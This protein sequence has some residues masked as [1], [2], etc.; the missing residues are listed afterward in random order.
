MRSADLSR[1][2][3]DIV[4]AFDEGVDEASPNTLGGSCDD[5]SLSSLHFDLHWVAQRCAC[6]Q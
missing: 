5:N 1:C 4:A 6:S 3:D 2:R